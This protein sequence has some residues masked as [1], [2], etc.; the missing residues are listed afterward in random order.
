MT[1]EEIMRQHALA[2]KTLNRVVDGVVERFE[3]RYKGQP[4]KLLLAVDAARAWYSGQELDDVV[5]MIPNQL[6]GTLFE[7]GRRRAER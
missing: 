3:A 7:V 5:A 4:G 2:V 6:Q 1:I